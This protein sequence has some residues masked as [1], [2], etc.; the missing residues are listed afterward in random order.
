MTIG[1]KADVNGDV[2]AR[3]LRSSSYCTVECNRGAPPNHG[4]VPPPHISKSH[5][6]NSLPR[7]SG[8]GRSFREQITTAYR[9]CARRVSVVNHR[10]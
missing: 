9:Q 3:T 1:E 7:C 4:S 2:T 8:A 6:A 10:G 5:A